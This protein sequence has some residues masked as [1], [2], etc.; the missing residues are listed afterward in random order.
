MRP[1]SVLHKTNGHRHLPKNTTPSEGEVLGLVHSDSAAASELDADLLRFAQIVHTEA[2]PGD[3]GAGLPVSLA[4]SLAE[5]RARMERGELSDIRGGLA[6]LHAQAEIAGWIVDRLAGATSG[7][8][9]APA[10]RAGLVDVNALVTRT[11]ERL[12]AHATVEPPVSTRLAPE[13]RPIVGDFEQLQDV[14]LILIVSIGP[15]MAAAGRPG[16]I[17]VETVQ[18]PG[19][20]RGE[21]IARIHIRHTPRPAG[22][23]PEPDRLTGQGDDEAPRHLAARALGEHGGAL[24]VARLPDGGVQFTLEFPTV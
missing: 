10:R 23:I 2:P 1:K 3:G 19:V 7:R 13:P 6:A 14:L 5:T 24:S 11:L 8:P 17:E 16:V 4:R 12:A 9:D 21:A 22:V 20:L 15:V 18:E